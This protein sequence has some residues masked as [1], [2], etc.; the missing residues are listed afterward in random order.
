M[1]CKA[2]VQSK[3]SDYKVTVRIPSIQK[4]LESIGATPQNQIPTATISIAPGI[5]PS[6][7]TGDTVIVSFED[8][9]LSRP[10]I[11]GIL[12]TQNCKGVLADIVGNSLVIKVNAKLPEET[13]VG[14]VTSKSIKNLEN[15]SENVQ[16]R[17]NKDK[18]R[19]NNLENSGCKVPQEIL[20]SISATLTNDILGAQFGI[21][22]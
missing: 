2:I 22:K 5:Y 10:I 4:G 15:L 20:N 7:R 11:L 16:D 9:D 19:L 8:D 18:K 3:L 14:K 6:L 1:V 21:K 12:Y 13:S 17:L